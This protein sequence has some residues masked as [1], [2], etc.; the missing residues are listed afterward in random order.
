M[1]NLNTI[2]NR[3]LKPVATTEK[4]CLFAVKKIFISA[5]WLVSTSAMASSS[6][7]SGDQAPEQMTV[8]I[9]PG[10]AENTID[11]TRQRR[12]PVAILGS[13]SFDVNDINPRTLRL[14]AVS[15]NLVGKSDKTL[16][17]QQDINEDSYMDLVCDIKM[18]G[19]GVQPGDIPV[20]ISVG[21]YQ[22]QSLRAEAVLK[23]IAE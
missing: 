13:A 2:F 8:D 14:K 9:L 11:L 7:L 6:L 16:C 19:F 22:R 5:C 23:Y 20:V 4:N 15:Q 12:L 18:I 1:L 3:Q 17:H 21:T 10:N